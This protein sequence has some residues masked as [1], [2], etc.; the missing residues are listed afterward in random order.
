MQ[1]ATDVPE[2]AYKVVLLM[3]FL[4]AF[5]IPLRGQPSNAEETPHGHVIQ[6]ISPSGGGPD[7]QL[8]PSQGN[9]ARFD[10]LASEL[11]GNG[12][13]IRAMQELKAMG[14]AA[15]PIIPYLVDILNS[16]SES[17]WETSVMVDQVFANLGPA[18]QEAV[19]ELIPMLSNE[20]RWQFAVYILRDLGPLASEAA[21][22]L[23]KLREGPACAALKRMGPSA[24]VAIPEL[25]RTI[26][27][28]KDQIPGGQN[29]TA[30]AC[31]VL[32]SIGPAATDAIPVL[33]SVVRVES[34]IDRIMIPECPADY[35]DPNGAAIYALAR[36]GRPART[37]LVDM[38]HSPDIVSRR[39]A[40][41]AICVMSSQVSREGQKDAESGD[42]PDAVVQEASRVFVEE[43]GCNFW[44]S[45]HASTTEESQRR[46]NKERAIIFNLGNLGRN[47]TPA[48]P[49][50]I[51]V[52]NMH[53]KKNIH[54][55]FIPLSEMCQEVPEAREA[56]AS[57]L[58]RSRPL[59]SKEQ[60][61]DSEFS[62]VLELMACLSDLQWRAAHPEIIREVE[63]LAQGTNDGIRANALRALE[64]LRARPETRSLKK[65]VGE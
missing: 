30:Q 60:L 1:R 50:L 21:I 47:A 15:K 4:V 16:I 33:L 8:L 12:T 24:K 20:S 43:L 34:Y 37:A 5:S 44:D 56:I 7:S 10:R 42:F 53:C 28:C 26:E 11:R 58:K 13:K 39:S 64:R 63:L 38:L 46:K 31:E 61:S 57:F 23:A 48:V 52:L 35:L 49:K 54:V 36:M 27:E 55:A 45:D 62:H 29:D 65:E 41:Q 3:S 17:D 18:A 2:S 9:D 32:G 40:A 19:P 51:E 22:P 25:I 14:P 6:A 59:A